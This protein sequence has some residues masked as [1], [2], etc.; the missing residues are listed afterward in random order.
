MVG[1]VQH[2]DVSVT[3]TFLALAAAAALTA[4]PA[5]GAPPAAAHHHADHARG[6]DGHHA[7]PADPANPQATPQAAPGPAHCHPDAAPAG[8]GQGH[9]HGHGHAAPAAGAKAGPHDHAEMK[10]M[11]EACIAAMK[12]K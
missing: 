11:H 6:G 3:K 10:K 4:G 1:D 12:A 5:L 2:K 9:P 7:G 8:A